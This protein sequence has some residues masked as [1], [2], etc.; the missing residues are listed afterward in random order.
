MGEAFR[1]LDDEG[2]L[3]IAASGND[4]NSDKSYPASYDHVMSVGAVDSSHKI[5]DF[6]Q[7]NDQV[8]ISAPGVG[9]KSPTG[10]SGYSTWQGTSMATPHVSGVALLLWNKYPDCTNAQIREALENGALDEGDQGRDDF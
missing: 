10:T 8:D 2:I 4:G 3:N 6:S 9:I 7:H 5:A 1:K